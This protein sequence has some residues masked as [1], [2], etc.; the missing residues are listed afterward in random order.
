[1]ADDQED[2]RI[3][4]VLEALQTQMV[5]GGSLGLSDRELGA[6]IALP[7]TVRALQT[8]METEVRAGMARQEKI[9]QTNKIVSGNG[10]PSKGLVLRV[11]RIEQSIARIE[12]LLWGL[13]LGTGV[14]LI[15]VA[16]DLL[17]LAAGKP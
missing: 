10:D 6:L 11:D 8:V 17:L 7:E 1:M 15:K 5:A 3:V 9:I 2:K 4:R 13:G 16:I 12:K 14:A